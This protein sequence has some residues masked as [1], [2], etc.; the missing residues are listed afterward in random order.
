MK[1][2]LKLGI[3]RL[4]QGCAG[5]MAL[6][7]LTAC[8]TV[9][10]SPQDPFEPMNRE[11]FQFNM[12]LDQGVLLP[13]ANV[14]RAVV[15]E[16][17]RTGVT[18][19]FGNLDDAYSLANNILQLRPTNAGQDL[20]RVSFNTVFGFGGLLDIASQLGIEKQNQDFGLTLGRWG[21]PSGPFLMLPF[22]GP[23]TLRD[24]GDDVVLFWGAPIVHVIRDWRWQ[25]V[26]SY[27]S[28][29]GTRADMIDTEGA[30][31]DAMLDPYQQLRDAYLQ[32]RQ[33]MLTGEMP[34]YDYGEY[35]GSEEASEFE[36]SVSENPA[37]LQKTEKALEIEK[38]GE[39]DTEL[40]T[41]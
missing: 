24:V 13:I 4:F 40:L 33:F 31:E 27:T 9:P 39:I 7:A 37:I 41:R 19:F 28:I 30:L 34:A 26:L 22:L 15:P 36:P 38:A 5:V 20:I 10:S 3:T 32:Q 23:R 35:D 18:N 25:M 29:L 16:I 14:Y 21:V 12:D 8:A 2:C 11:F 1:V 17:A 6:V